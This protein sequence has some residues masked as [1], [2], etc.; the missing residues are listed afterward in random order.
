[1][2]YRRHTEWFGVRSDC[3]LRASLTVLRR[4]QPGGV[5]VDPLIGIGCTPVVVKGTK[6]RFLGWMGH[7]LKRGAITFPEHGQPAAWQVPVSFSAG[8]PKTEDVAA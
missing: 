8:L 2:L 3:R 1:M 4:S 5:A 7:A 6:K